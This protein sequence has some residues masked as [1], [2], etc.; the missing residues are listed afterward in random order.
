MRLHTP[1]GGTVLDPFAGAGTAGVAAMR[2]GREAV[3]IELE[4]KWCEMAAKRL[5]KEQS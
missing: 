5:E 2:T 3:L 1:E 4:E